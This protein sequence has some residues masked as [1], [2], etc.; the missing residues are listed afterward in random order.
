MNEKLTRKPKSAGAVPKIITLVLSIYLLATLPL[1][2]AEHEPNHRY[3]VT[4]YVRDANGNPLAGEAV[5]VTDTSIKLTEKG[6]TDKNGK[7]SILLHLHDNN[8]GDDLT[9]TARGVSFQT[10]VSFDPADKATERT[11]RL[12]LAG[13][14]WSIGE[15]QRA[16]VDI[17]SGVLLVVLIGGAALYLLRSSGKGSKGASPKKLKKKRI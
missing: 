4:G 3:T 15:A 12:D 14:K 17:R 5:T 16:G 2:F 7:Y 6:V 9:I 13:E 11:M 10:K 8:L 1:V